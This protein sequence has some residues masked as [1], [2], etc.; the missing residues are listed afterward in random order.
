M[1]T[2]HKLP[3]LQSLD[4]PIFLENEETQ[5]WEYQYVQLMQLY[6][7]AHKVVVMC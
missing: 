1:A 7:N 6:S 4:P 2:G 5:T 3:T